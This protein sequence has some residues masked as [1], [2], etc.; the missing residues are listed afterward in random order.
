[1]PDLSQESQKKKINCITVPCDK[2]QVI[3]A[4]GFF[5]LLHRTQDFPEDQEHSLQPPIL[6]LPQS[7]HLPINRRGLKTNSWEQQG[8]SPSVPSD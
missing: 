5:T 2:G 4:Q 6:L 8:F 1:M 3:C 7:T